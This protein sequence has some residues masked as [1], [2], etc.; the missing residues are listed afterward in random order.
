MYGDKIRFYRKQKGL[1]QQDI[2]QLLHIAPATYSKIETSRTSLTT[3]MLE[4]I[5]SALGISP[6]DIIREEPVVTK[7]NDSTN[8]SGTVNRWLNAE[9]VFDYQ[10]ELVDSLIASKDSEISILKQ[11]I[12]NLQ[13][14]LKRK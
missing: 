8:N 3:D 13:E 9:T 6:L 5:A 14:L 4:K 10:K 2:S 12:E 11:T 1:S 7:F